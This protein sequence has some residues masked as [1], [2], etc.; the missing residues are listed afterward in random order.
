MFLPVSITDLG[1]LD[2]ILQL[3]CSDMNSLSSIIS[4]GLLVEYF[5]LLKQKVLV[6]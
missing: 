4:E 1:D 5:A 2:R 6:V 3:F